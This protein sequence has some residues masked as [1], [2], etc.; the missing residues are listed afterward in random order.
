MSQPD[1]LK[2]MEKMLNKALKATS[3]QITNRL[4]REIRKLGQRTADLETRVDDIE[5]IIQ[6]HAQEQAALRE[7]NATLL[8]RLEDAENRSR[9]S[10]LCLRGI[11]EEVEDVQS[12]TTALFQELCPSIPIE[13]LEFDRIQRALTRRQ[14][15]GPP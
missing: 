5:L 2:H 13:R 3:D 12:F 15:D 14:Q 7:E 8:S 1:F 9:R 10:N 6:E 11:P 4:S